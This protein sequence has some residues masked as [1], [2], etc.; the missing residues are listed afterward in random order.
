VQQVKIVKNPFK[1]ICHDPKL[2]VSKLILMLLVGKQ[3][4]SK[5]VET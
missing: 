1:S 2:A 5:Y 3:N 4:R